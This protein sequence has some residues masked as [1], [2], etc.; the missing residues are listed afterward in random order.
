MKRLF[1]FLSLIVMLYTTG[2]L[3]AHTSGMVEKTCPLCAEAFKC[4]L[5]MSGTQFGMRPDLKPLGAIAAPRRIPV[6]PGCRFVL[7]DD[8]IPTEELAKCREIVQ[9]D[10]YQKKNYGV[11]S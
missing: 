6:C 8:E 9:G 1:R 4:E 10:A 11:T 3:Y 7:Y 5:N 2:V